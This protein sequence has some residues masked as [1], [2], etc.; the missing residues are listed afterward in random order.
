[1]PVLPDESRQ[2]GR[3][4]Q[5]GSN[6]RVVVYAGDDPVTG[7]RSYLRESVKGNDKAAYKRANTVLTRLLAQ[8]EKQRVTETSISLGEVLEEWLK[9]AEMEDSTRAGY[10][11]Y[12]ERNIRPALGALAARKVTARVLESFNAELRRCRERC[13]GKPYIA[14]KATG[15]HDCLSVGCKPHVCKPL[16]ASTVRQIHAVISGAMAAA[17]RWEWLDDNPAR[18]AHRPRQ[19]PSQP[20]PPSAAEAALLIE[21][22]FEVDDDW[23]TLVWLVMTTGMRRGEVCALRWDHI[24]LDLGVLEIRQSYIDR[25]G[26]KKIKDTKTHQMRRIALDTETVVLLGELR[27]RCI[28]RCAALNIEFTGDLYVFVGVRKP[29]PRVPCK[30]DSISGRYKYM[31]TKLGIETHIHELRHYS[32]TELLTAGVDLRTV[33]GRLGHGGGGATTLRVY[34]AW[35][36]GADRKAAEILASRMPK[37]RPKP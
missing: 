4:E 35:V 10:R 16:A 36:A 22:A 26:I 25:G 17:V 23:G 37:R 7:K 3:I 18:K 2:R 14:H 29:H 1:M 11:G 9:V 13:D 8:V 30:P 34:A 27:Q 19:S 28:Q 21:A 6:L 33:A 5:R 15:L 32:A 31:A 12:I 24:D 20:D